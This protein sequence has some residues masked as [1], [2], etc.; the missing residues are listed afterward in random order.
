MR[1][2]VDVLRL[3][4]PLSLSIIIVRISTTTI[5]RWWAW[6]RLILRITLVL[7][8]DACTPHTT[9]V[10]TGGPWGL[11][12]GRTATHSDSWVQAATSAAAT[13]TVQE[14]ADGLDG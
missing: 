14:T 4:N 11:H 12:L 6:G 1:R 5:V 10:T 2:L 9:P 7:I 8:I 3:C 13:S